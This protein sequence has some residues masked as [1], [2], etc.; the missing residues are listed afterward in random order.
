MWSFFGPMTSDISGLVQTTFS[1]PPIVTADEGIYV[2]IPHFNQEFTLQWHRYCDGTVGDL[3]RQAINQ[4]MLADEG[5][6]IARYSHLIMRPRF[7]MFIPGLDRQGDEE[8]VSRVISPGELVLIL[9]DTEARSYVSSS[10]LVVDGSALESAIGA[11][12]AG[13]GFSFEALSS[14]LSTRMLEEARHYA[15][16][17][18]IAPPLSSSDRLLPPLLRSRD[19][20]RDDGIVEGVPRPVAPSLFGRGSIGTLSS[21]LTNTG[22]PELPLT[23]SGASAPLPAGGSGSSGGSGRVIGGGGLRYSR[24]TDE[25][26]RARTRVIPFPQTEQIVSI[27]SEAHTTMQPD[28]EEDESEDD[29]IPDLRPSDLD[30]EFVPPHTRPSTSLSVFGNLLSSVGGIGFEGVTSILQASQAAAVGAGN[31]GGVGSSMSAAQDMIGLIASLS[32]NVRRVPTRGVQRFD[33]G[34]PT[35]SVK[36]VITLAV[37][38]RVCPVVSDEEIASQIVGEQPGEISILDQEAVE[39]DTIGGLQD[40]GLGTCTICLSLLFNRT[41]GRR[42]LRRM[43][44]CSHTFHES[45]LCEWLT[46]NAITCPVC[47]EP[48]VT[49]MADYGYLGFGSGTEFTPASRVFV[50]RD[51]TDSQ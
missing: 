28:S 13:Q 35:T 9:S 12:A 39:D 37:F 29:Q 5:A 51:S 41:R 49:D 15:E 31:T 46:K 11:A 10:D 27:F 42:Q 40:S 44:M 38:N 21:F 33:D 23:S 26:L 43:P 6:H 34:V 7:S 17:H 24:P 30:E 18:G 36:K 3:V 8:I 50:E 22:V 32:A 25:A 1:M 16:R 47:R 14:A 19:P 45:C 48:A 4:A 20:P 2:T